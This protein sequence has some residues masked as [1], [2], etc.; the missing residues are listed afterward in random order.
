MP[1]AVGQG[2]FSQIRGHVAGTACVG[3]ITT[4]TCA[5]FQAQ[6]FVDVGLGV[7]VGDGSGIVPLGR[8][9]NNWDGR[10]LRKCRRE[11][12]PSLNGA[13]GSIAEELAQLKL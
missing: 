11:Q 7:E 12:P 9:G 6:P 8:L 2:A 10:V 3:V 4:A 13:K 5:A 1:I